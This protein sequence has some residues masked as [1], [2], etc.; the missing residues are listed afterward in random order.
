MSVVRF[1]LI[2]P[3]ALAVLVA[4]MTAVPPPGGTAPTAAVRMSASTALAA[5]DAAAS[6]SPHLLAGSRSFPT[7]GLASAATT[8]SF[9]SATPTAEPP[10]AE[11]SKAPAA[12]IKSGGSSPALSAS[13]TPYPVVTPSQMTPARQHVTRILFTD[14]DTD[15][16]NGRQVEPAQGGTEF[17]TSADFID[18]F[19]DYRDVMPEDVIRTDWYRDGRRFVHWTFGYADRMV[20]RDLPTSYIMVGER[21]AYPGRYRL[22][23]Y[24]N[25]TLEDAGEFTLAVGARAAA[26]RSTAVHNLRG[27]AARG[28]DGRA[29][30]G[31]IY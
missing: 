25:D 24:V 16:V 29:A 1:N 4:L 30:A 15:I 26:D 11:A 7:M 31:H 6:L 20:S 28:V 3:G 5:T 19:I 8:S 18:A 10:G 21:L 9:A 12:A 27:P 13:P 17:D 14:K 23:V 22:E 2:A